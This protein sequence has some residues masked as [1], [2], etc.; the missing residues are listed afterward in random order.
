MI[1]RFSD[2]AAQSDDGTALAKVTRA[3]VADSGTHILFRHGKREDAELTAAEL[4]LP[5]A[6][7]GVLQKLPIHRALV[8]C[9]GRLAVVEARFNDTLDTLTDTNQAMGRVA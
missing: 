2:L 8:H 6:A 7:V 9:G 1:H 4:S 3:L 5:A